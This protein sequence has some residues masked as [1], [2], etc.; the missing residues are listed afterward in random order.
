MDKK[1]EERRP[2]YVKSMNYGKNFVEIKISPEP[3]Q[4]KQAIV[5]SVKCVKI[6]DSEYQL[7]ME[8]EDGLST[9][10]KGWFWRTDC[11]IDKEAFVKTY[12]DILSG[13]I[14]EGV[15]VS[16]EYNANGIMKFYL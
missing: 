14:A 7:H 8:T 16:I 12:E 2:T 10:N 9:P 15:T 3:N 6:S 4:I 5:K 1:G 13:N 11:S